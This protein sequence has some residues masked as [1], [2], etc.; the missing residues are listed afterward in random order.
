[1]CKTN[2]ALIG[3]LLFEKRTSVSEYFFAPLDD[4]TFLNVGLNCVTILRHIVLNACTVITYND[5]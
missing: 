3:G 5:T 1:M 2:I 4:V